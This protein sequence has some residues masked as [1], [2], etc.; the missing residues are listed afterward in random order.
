MELNK[1]MDRRSFLASVAAGGAASLA[2]AG[3]SGGNGASGGSD[4]G[5]SAAPVEGKVL[6]AA[7]TGYF[8]VESMD[9]ANSWDG[10]LMQ[11]QGITEN[12]L[13]LADD[14]S[15]EPWLAEDVTDTDG[16][17]WEFTLR[18][19]VKFSNGEDMT[20]EAVKACLD[21]TYE[22]NPRAAET[23][24]I[25]SIEAVDGKLV[26]TLPEASP[27]FKN[28]ICD[29][30]FSIY[31]VGDDVDYANA[32][33]CTGPYMAEE[34]IFEDHT[35]LVPNPYYWNGTP[36]LDRVTCNNYFDD[37]SMILA[38]Q[39]GELNVLAMPGAA[40][41]T[42]LV[43]NGDF[44]KHACPTTRADFL[45]FNMDHPVVAEQ[46]VRTA[47]SFC[48]DRESYA[49]V[50]NQGTEV[51]SYGVYSSQL[52]YGGTDG[53]DVTVDRFDTAAAAEVLDAAGIKDN[54]GDGVRELADGTPVNVKACIFT[55]YDRFSK[56]ADD[57]QSKLSSV[58]I[59]MEIVPTDYLLE[60]AESYAQADPDF[61]LDSYAMAPTGDPNYFA[62]MCFASN[63]SAN[64]GHYNNPEVDA[65]V[66]QFATTF[67]EEDR[68][69]L[70]RQI[71]QKVLDDCAY[72]FFA[73]S[74]TSFIAAPG[75][76]GFAVAPS[77]YYFL[78]VDTDIA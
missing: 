17:V 6:N 9:P 42:T 77:E 75:V 57:L 46:A 61:S 44:V 70:A 53:L 30:L 24:A 64:F 4:A 40:A 59:K 37:D 12:L 18:E 21:R 62:S 34:F 67:D 28:N 3:C 7:S 78:T 35:T 71:S 56:L 58:G 20:A 54:D 60:D 43:D 32:T 13:K 63:G 52:F 36:L 16:R 55:S 74:E 38:M 65:L 41:Y 76:S 73:N 68:A 10:W 8:Y 51:P 2:L 72:I 33:P 23:I 1:N 22:V 14:F 26:I 25:E 69:D 49:D 48:I 50:I 31:Y 66:A 39:N 27:S 15:V 19:G 45:R 29:P 5:S 47:I 11:Y